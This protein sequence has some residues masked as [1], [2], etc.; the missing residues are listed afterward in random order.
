MNGSS[1]GFIVPMAKTNL[2]VK[3]EY[4]G[5]LNLPSN[6]TFETRAGCTDI[7]TDIFDPILWECAGHLEFVRSEGQR[8]NLGPIDPDKATD[9]DQDRYDQF[10][11]SSDTDNERCRESWHVVLKV[12]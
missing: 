4:H 9:E 10:F 7:Y 11:S 1:L 5:S 12:K 6:V 3:C 8:L 2:T